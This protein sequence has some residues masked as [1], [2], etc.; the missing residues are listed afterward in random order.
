MSGASVCRA[1]LQAPGDPG[2]AMIADCPRVPTTARDIEA[3]GVDLRPSSK[4]AF[5]MPL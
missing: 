5:S 4:S 2:K 1:S 3:R